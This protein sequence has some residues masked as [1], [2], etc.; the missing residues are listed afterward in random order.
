MEAPV[1]TSPRS[2]ADDPSS[3]GRGRPAVAPTAVAP[4]PRNAPEDRTEDQGSTSPPP[5]IGHGPGAPR[6]SHPRAPAG[7][8][9]PP[10]STPGA[11][12]PPCLPIGHPQKFLQIGD[13]D[14]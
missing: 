5:P 12:K 10:P 1:P 3:A 6:A 8:A 14:D 2:P 9:W 4:A 11:R 13:V 7:G